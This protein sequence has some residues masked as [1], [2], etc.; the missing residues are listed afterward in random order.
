MDG[1]KTAG[2]WQQKTD[3]RLRDYGRQEGRVHG[4]KRKGRRAR[5]LD[6]KQCQF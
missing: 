3:Y 2:S 1:R 6:I 4:A 5:G